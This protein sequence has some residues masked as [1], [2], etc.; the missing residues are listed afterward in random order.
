MSDLPLRDYAVLS[1]DPHAD[2]ACCQHTRLVEQPTYLDIP[3]NVRANSANSWQGSRPTP[4]LP[5]ATSSSAAAL[6][7][8]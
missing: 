3:I 7:I 6:V 4:L 8:V 5:P 1:M 2:C